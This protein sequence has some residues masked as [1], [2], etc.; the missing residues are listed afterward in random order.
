M[1]AKPRDPQATVGVI[2]VN[3]NGLADTL[4][5]L[6]ELEGIDGPPLRIIVV[7][8]GSSDDSVE[9]LRREAPHVEV[10]ETGENLGF[11]GGNLVGL[12]H[13]FESKDFGWVLLI[14][15]M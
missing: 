4:A 15:T 10:V 9:V 14:N 1:S 8:N 5:V 2:I 13:A 6:G 7:D 12:R 3:W 11:A